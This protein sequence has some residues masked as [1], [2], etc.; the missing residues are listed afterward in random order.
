MTTAETLERIDAANFQLLTNAVLAHSSPLYAA[1]IETGSNA[2]GQTVKSPLD[3]FCQVPGSQPPHFVL[4]EHT[5][6]AKKSKG[7]DGNLAA[8]WKGDLKKA[9]QKAAHLQTQHPSAVF[10]VILTSSQRPTEK[11]LE[12]VYEQAKS[13]E[14][15][16]DVDIWEQSRIARFLDT[17]EGH[18]LRKTYLGIEAELL[19]PSLLQELCRRSIDEYERFIGLSELPIAREEDTSFRNALTAHTGLHFVVGDSGLGKSTLLWGAAKDQ[20]EHGGY[21][22]WIPAHYLREK[23]SLEAT[24]R[25]RLRDLYPSLM[26]GQDADLRELLSSQQTLTVIVDDPNSE[27]DP[28]Q[29]I[30]H[31]I[32]WMRPRTKDDSALASHTPRF[33]SSYTL[34][35]PLWPHIWAAHNLSA[36]AW[37][38]TTLLGTFSQNDAVE[39]INL[40]LKRAGHGFLRRNVEKLAE[41][42]SHDPFLIG[43][44]GELILL[45]STPL[46][47]ARANELAANAV[48]RYVTIK[49]HSSAL[50]SSA[51]HS[52]TDFRE[53]LARFGALLLERRELAPTWAQYR[54]WLRAVDQENDA[55]ILN[56]LARYSSLWRLQ[57]DGN[58]LE[59]RPTYRHDR[60]RQPFLVEAM[61]NRLRHLNA[62]SPPDPESMALCGDPFFAE[63]VGEAF[64]HLAPHDSQSL[65]WRHLY[66][67]NPLALAFAYRGFASRRSRPLNVHE[68]TCRNLLH[69][70]L[71]QWAREAASKQGLETTIEAI[72]RAFQDV[73]EPDLIRMLQPLGSHWAIG[74]V[75]LR[76]GAISTGCLKCLAR[77]WDVIDPRHDPTVVQ[78]SLQ[79]R[80]TLI[81]QIARWL[82]EDFHDTQGAECWQGAIVLAANFGFGEFI[83][84]LSQAWRKV[85]PS[86]QQDFLPLFVWATLHCFQSGFADPARHFLNE[87]SG[88]WII[89]SDERRNDR[90]GTSDRSEVGHHLHHIVYNDWPS[91][92]LNYLV[93]A[94]RSRS[95]LTHAIDIAL[96]RVDN[97]L[98]LDFFVRQMNDEDKSEHSTMFLTDHWSD[99]WGGKRRR[100][101]S[102]ESLQHVRQLWQNTSLNDKA[103]RLAFRYWRTHPDGDDPTL[104]ASITASE[105]FYYDA[106]QTRIRRGDLSVV[107][108]L[109]PLL[110]RESFLWHEAHLVWCPAIYEAAKKLATDIHAPLPSYSDKMPNSAY[111]LL[112]L[113]KHIP[114]SDAESILVGN[115]EHLGHLADFLPAAL[116]VGTPRCLELV[117][118]EINNFPPEMRVF[119]HLS[120]TLEIWPSEGEEEAARPQVL[121]FL[122]NV[123]P[124]WDRLDPKR[125][126]SKVRRKRPS[127]SSALTQGTQ[128]FT[129]EKM[130]EIMARMDMRESNHLIEV[131]LR[132]GAFDWGRQYLYPIVNA[133]Q[134][135]EYFPSD[136]DLHRQLDGILE[137]Q[138]PLDLTRHAHG[139][140]YAYFSQRERHGVPRE[141]LLSVLLDWLA[142]SPEEDRCRLAIAAVREYGTRSDFQRLNETFEFWNGAEVEQLRPILDSAHFVVVRRSLK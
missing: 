85:P 131:C 82:V 69:E 67:V 29:I 30:S 53:A 93:Q 55:Q 95:E 136:F 105:P 42:L 2:Q 32:S 38:Q 124:Y 68:R 100:Y 54:E 34:L 49:C 102:E 115:W 133:T 66:S 129:P 4:V 139:A 13:G 90:G 74:L 92:A 16:V 20:L 107:P 64:C 86:Q 96:S 75:L 120:S 123:L 108:E 33:N 84:P 141:R 24:I 77:R 6:T 37:C 47:C 36:A 63:V 9:V 50:Q 94:A 119:S 8:K 111:Y 80:P 44:W 138:K 3:A 73:D 60:L 91:E 21:A 48:E 114:Q 110:E 132:V 62:A 71:S 76:N 112:R 7:K 117:K 45:E 101:L 127:P 52:A 134:K 51:F 109:L 40:W 140:I 28:S 15:S 98:V 89:L 58:L 23:L 142:R 12:E 5:I 26:V 46:D 135:S 56:E 79:H 19:S 61:A 125:E 103:R 88:T 72:G 121:R 43:L 41:L 22:L 87:L 11:L 25:R 118:Q 83:E 116:W 57:Q 27:S 128:D 137:R 70:E 39:A 104:L 1:I 97:L 81:E 126:T 106:L 17:G 35:C 14:V 99:H 65:L 10:T 31:L 122:H 59:A 18:Y 113:L 78:S 130:D